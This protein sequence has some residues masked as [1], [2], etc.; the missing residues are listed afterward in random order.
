MAKATNIRMLRFAF[1]QAVL[2]APLGLIAGILYSF[3]GFF[4]ELFTNSL[5]SG[6]A[7]AFLAL[8]GM[9]AIFGAAGFVLGLLEAVLFNLL[10]SWF[11]GMDLDFGQQA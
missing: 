10:A 8:A 6:T 11:G 5:N 2:A 9:P 7:L 3:G 4:Y 1:F